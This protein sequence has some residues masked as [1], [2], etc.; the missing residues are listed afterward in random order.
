MKPL[1]ESSQV[2]V[3]YAYLAVQHKAKYERKKLDSKSHKLILLGYTNNRKAYHLRDVIFNETVA[4]YKQNRSENES[5]PYVSIDASEDES[6][7]EVEMPNTEN[8]E[9]VPHNDETREE[10]NETEQEPE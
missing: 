6:T 9:T 7:T 5:T 3:T 8:E 1:L 2:L 4:C 10:E